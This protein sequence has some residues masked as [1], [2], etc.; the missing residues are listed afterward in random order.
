VLGMTSVKVTATVA[1]WTDDSSTTQVD[2]P[3]NVE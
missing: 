3:I 1:G 2:L